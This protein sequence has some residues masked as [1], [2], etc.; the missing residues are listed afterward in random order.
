[1]AFGEAIA[2]NEDEAFRALANE[3]GAIQQK[4]KSAN[5]GLERAL[6]VKQHAGAVGELVVTA[7]ESA[8][9][10]VFAETGKRWP[11]YVR[12]SN[13]GS[14]RQSDSAPDARGF[15]LK[16]VGVPGKKLIEGLEAEL[17]QDFLFIDTPSIPFKDPD[18]FVAFVRAAKDGPG[19]LVPRLVGS[20]GFSRAFGILWGAVTAPKLT[21]YA[22]HDF[23]TGAPIA[24][25]A[26]AAKLGLF[27]ETSGDP[28]VKRQ[29]LNALGEDLAA[30]LRAGSLRWSLRAQR[31]VNE[32]TTPIED[33]SRAW[34][35][36]WVA[37]GTLVL[38]KQDLASLAG[39]EVTELVSR[40]SF[41]P[42]HALEAHRPLGAIM[43]AR[44]VAYATSVIARGAAPEPREPP[45]LPV[46][47]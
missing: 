4:R 1:M 27:P 47:A 7:E 6:H 25:G 15:A 12:F 32:T 28:G 40:L 9:H 24:F 2:V 18:E 35:G 14:R 46:G 17:T 13:G 36:P 11:V 29:G 21:S 19:P 10:G 26:G 3:I 33:T 34:S 23:H 8:R 43:R 5:G 31:Y 42:W 44:R 41:D 37:L 30:R 39:Q 22:T 16:L 38:P 20:F 45:A